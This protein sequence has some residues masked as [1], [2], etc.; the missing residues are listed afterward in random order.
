MNRIQITT[1][2]LFSQSLSLNLRKNREKLRKILS[3][4]L[5][6]EMPQKPPRGIFIY[7]IPIY[8][9]QPAFCLT[10]SSQTAGN[11]TD[12]VIGY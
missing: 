6:K 3:K 8:A 2:F 11:L 5:Q 7:H 1:F 9:L 12:T 4:K 10:D